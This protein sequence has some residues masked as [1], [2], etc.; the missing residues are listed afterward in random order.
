[1]RELI[2]CDETKCRGCNRCLRVCPVSE[3]NIAYFDNGNIKVK[4]NPSKCI[5]CGACISVCQHEARE[6]TDDTQLFLQDLAR[7]EQISL[8][9]APAGR[10]NFKEWQRVLLWLREMG[11]R[12]VYD[13]SLGA[14][15]CTWA[16]IRHLQSANTHPLITQPCPAIVN[17]ITKYRHALINYLSPIHSPMLCTAVFAKNCLK[18]S[19]KLAALSPCIAKSS[20]FEDT[21]LIQYNVTFARLLNYIRSRDIALP[22]GDFCFDSVEASLGRIYSMPGGLKEN[23][24]FYLGKEIRIDKSEGQDNVYLALDAYAK[25]DESNLPSVFDVLN[26]PEGCNLGT[27]CANEASIFEVGRIMDDARKHSMALY[28]KDNH[29]AM[30]ALFEAFDAE[31]KLSD[32][33]RSYKKQETQHLDVSEEDIENAFLALEKRTA[34]ERMHNCYACGSYTCREM[35]ER[36]AKGINIPENCIEKNRHKIIREH[37]AFINEKSNNLN[38]INQINQEI[39]EVKRLYDDVLDG[40]GKIEQAMVQYAQMAKEI[41]H[42]AMQTNLLSVNASIEAAR[43][44]AAG[45][46]FGVVAQAIRELAQQSQKSVEEVTVTSIQA[47]QALDYINDAGGKVDDTVLR[48]SDYIARISDSL[49]KN[50]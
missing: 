29:A 3:A 43:A 23:M 5:A 50:Q 45:K 41:T 6:Y 4:I 16:H 26:C 20:E 35:A 1:M 15:I 33:F 28:Q 42:M 24:E 21:G 8:I 37:Q 48:M 47:K 19:D 10:T 7:G 13:V 39:S 27:A 25:E 14:D 18:N 32:F 46:G 11:V 9:V 2:Q 34:E 44:G 22:E 40:I 30:T 38:Q 12:A 36:I 17:Y 49:Q 31:L